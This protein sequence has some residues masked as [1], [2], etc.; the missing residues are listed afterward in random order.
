MSAVGQLQ[1]V[2]TPEQIRDVA[3][4]IVSR[5]EFSGPSTW[6]QFLY[7]LWR[8]L[9]EWLKSMVAWSAQNPE[10]ARIVVI[11]LIVT[12][13]ALLVHLL[14]LALGDLLPFGRGKNAAPARASRWEILEGAARNWREAL[15]AAR[16]MLNEGDCR[17]AIWLA[18]RVLLG[19]LDEQE[20]VRF[21][22]WKT[23]SNYLVECAPGHPW[24]STFA[25]L[26]EVYEQ[27]IYARRAAAPSSVE[28]LISRVD[29]MWKER[30]E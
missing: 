11:V 27:A 9:A 13:V 3:Q 23:N 8:A 28:S 15:D 4:E 14:Y 6:E 16:K 10:L 19:L 17:R 26:T 2:P 25:E 22:G 24:Y 12:A 18:H 1:S 7:S 5:P 20:A 21:A 30:Y 29:R